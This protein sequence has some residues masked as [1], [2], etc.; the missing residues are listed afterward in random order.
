MFSH[1]LGGLD[2]FTARD[3][4]VTSI[5]MVASQLKL[6]MAFRISFCIIGLLSN[7]LA[8]VVVRTNYESI[9]QRKVD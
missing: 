8:E 6:T 1:L 5:T 4:V 7:L 3:V 9:D 2:S